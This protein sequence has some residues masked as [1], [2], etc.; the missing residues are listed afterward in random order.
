MIFPCIIFI[1]YVLIKMVIFELLISLTRL[2]IL[3]GL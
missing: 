2:C 3:I 1:D